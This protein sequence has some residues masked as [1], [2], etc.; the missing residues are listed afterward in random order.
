[1]QA[2]L[3]QAVRGI[4]ASSLVFA[5]AVFASSRAEASCV[6]QPYL[7]SICITAADYCPT[8]YA[9]ASGQMMPITQNTALF[10]LIGVKYG[11]DGKTT[12]ALPKLN[13]NPNMKAPFVKL[14][15]CIATY[16]AWPPK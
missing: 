8:G 10:S 12:F 14:H 5:L 13:G 16:G 6:P 15:Y 3:H 4:A 2:R 11:G 1:M 9:D 7:A